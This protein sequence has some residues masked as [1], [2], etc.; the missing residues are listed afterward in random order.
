MKNQRLSLF[1]NS[2]IASVWLIN[3]LFCK[4]LNFVPRHAQIVKEITQFSN[5]ELLT[6]IIGISEI[7]MAIWI[8]SKI[9]SRLNSVFQ[10]LIISTMNII[11]FIFVPKLL[12]WG[13]LNIVFALALIALIYYKEFILKKISV[14]NQ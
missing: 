1:L 3:G 4:V 5:Y 7:L 10:I 12:L 9:K 8:I 2:L 13:R 6:I 14:D 11:E